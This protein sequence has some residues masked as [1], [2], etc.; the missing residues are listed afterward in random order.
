MYLNLHIN[1]MVF[2]YET[3]R[4]H[5]YFINAKLT[6][7]IKMEFFLYAK[8]KTGHLELLH[9][10]IDKI[11]PCIVVHAFNNIDTLCQ[12][13]KNNTITK[14]NRTITLLL[15]DDREELQEVIKRHDQLSETRIMLILPD[16]EP[17]TIKLG[18]RL[19]PRYQDF[20]DS[21]FTEVGEVLR[22]L[23]QT[24]NREAKK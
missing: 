6:K 20:I 1:G 12:Q 22:K 9:R 11:I 3:Y 5:K 14:N 19:F 13:L 15:I 16:K 18:H 2:E 7:Q 21:N 17:E 23:I 4:A 8:R 10:E 24:D